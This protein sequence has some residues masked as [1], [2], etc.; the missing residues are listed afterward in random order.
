MYKIKSVHGHDSMTVERPYA[1]IEVKLYKVL[2]L[3]A[4]IH[5]SG[6]KC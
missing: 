3:G 4:T 2:K 6:Q 1:M 5:T